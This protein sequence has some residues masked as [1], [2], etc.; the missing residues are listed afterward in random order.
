MENRSL[1]DS[2]FSLPCELQLEVL[3]Y[4]D[5]E[6]ISALR[7]TSRA[8]YDAAQVHQTPI[9]RRL[10]T[11]LE[12]DGHPYANTSL[13]SPPPMTFV[14]YYR[15]EALIRKLTPVIV[16]HVE[17]IVF[18]GK[19]DSRMNPRLFMVDK[20]FPVVK[21]IVFM[22]E[23][24][25]YALKSM[26]D[27]HGPLHCAT[28]E[29]TQLH[30]AREREILSGCS[31][32]RLREILAVLKLLDVLLRRRLRIPEGLGLWRGWMWTAE[33]YT[34]GGFE[35]VTKLLATKADKDEYVPLH[36]CSSADCLSMR[37]SSSGVRK[38]PQSLLQIPHI[39]RASCCFFPHA[40]RAGIRMLVH[41]LKHVLRTNDIFRGTIHK[42]LTE[43]GDN[44]HYG[45]SN[46]FLDIVGR[47]IMTRDACSDVDR[48][49]I[50]ILLRR[51]VAV[52]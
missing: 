52:I 45:R 25:H 24:Y 14:Y 5:R 47:W 30:E 23:G 50:S 15:R 36:L 31:V 3:L 20:F 33:I 16:D 40:S 32:T 44:D 7:L 18:R 21:H 12:I 9:V 28:E 38:R 29:I 22:F 26:F 13:S 46:H 11:L 39:S 4:L 43:K 27:R 48:S 17:A 42:L 2:F 35:D 51:H 10:L 8:F 41:Y 1:A 6:A 34:L 49:Q 19:R 37:M